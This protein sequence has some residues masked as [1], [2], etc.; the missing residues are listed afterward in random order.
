MT[1]EQKAVNIKILDKEYGIACLAEEEDELI[2]SARIVDTHMREIRRNG[3]VIG[4][5][6]IA[7]MVA[8]N[9]A[10]EL[11]KTKKE[12]DQQESATEKQLAKIQ[13]KIEQALANSQKTER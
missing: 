12:L 9:I 13:D 3:N 11:V 5:E 8:L 4:M 2:D 7:I 1:K 6:R 10:H